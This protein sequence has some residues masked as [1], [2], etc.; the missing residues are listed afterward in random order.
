VTVRV[1]GLGGETE[2]VGT[3]NR[4]ICLKDSRIEVR[5]QVWENASEHD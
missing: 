3:K 1:T 2:K 5:I 4:S